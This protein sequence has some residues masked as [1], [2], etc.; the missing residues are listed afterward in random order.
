[1]S[2]AFLSLLLIFELIHQAPLMNFILYIKFFKMLNIS[3]EKLHI[4]SLLRFW[5]NT[6]Q[7]AT[8]SKSMIKFWSKFHF[9]ILCYRFNWDNR[10][11]L[12]PSLISHR[13]ILP[14][15]PLDTSTT[16]LVCIFSPI[17]N[18]MMEGWKYGYREKKQERRH[19]LE[20][21]MKIFSDICMKYLNPQVRINKMVNEHNVDY[22]PSPSE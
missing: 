15:P 22:H 18:S 2:V 16:A 5:N 14:P 17:L 21:C 4:S 12:N 20:I 1:M 3:K 19:F 7:T 10:F 9:Q 8:I 13:K 6:V 11:L